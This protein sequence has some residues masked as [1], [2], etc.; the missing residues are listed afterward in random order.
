M[1]A[2]MQGRPTAAE[3]LAAVAD[4]LESDVRGAIDGQVNFHARVAANVLRMVERELLHDGGP[5]AAL[6]RL[7]FA[8]EAALAT[9]IRD[10]ELDDRNEDVT[11]FLR[12]LV[13]HRLAAA[14][15]GYAVTAVADR[16]FAAMEAGDIDAVAAM[17]SDDVAVWHVGDGRI[18]DKT[19]GLKVVSWFVS[20]TADRHYDVLARQL[21]DGGFV[22]QHVLHGTAR[23]GTP[24]TMRVAMIITVGADG[25]INRIDEYFDPAALAPL[26]NQSA[27]TPRR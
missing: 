10:G 8:D 27:P 18:R 26:L 24:Y 7:G 3:L 6:T 13:Q 1:T 12:T 16:L 22:Q 2:S 21:F 4:F 20:A 19:R 9:A 5:A 14:H 23:G 15:P 11:A 25:L 17:W